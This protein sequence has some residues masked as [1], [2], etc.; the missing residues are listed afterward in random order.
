MKTVL[1]Y[2]VQKRLSMENENV[3][4]EALNFIINSSEAARSGLM[5]L[6]HGIDSDLPILRFQTQQTDEGLRPDFWGLDG[7]EPRVFIENKF[8]AGLTE[9]QPKEYLKLLT[10]YNQPTVLLLVVPEARLDSVWRELLQRIRLA[11]MSLTEKEPSSNIYRVAK[12]NIGPFLA[13]T[14]WNK[15][16]SAIEVELIDEPRTRNDLLQLR[17]LC[18]AADSD[19]FLPISAEELTNQRYPALILQLNSVVQKVVE[20][21]VNEKILLTE[22]LRPTHFWDSIGRYLSFYQAKHVYAWLGI[23]FRLWRQYGGTPLWLSFNN[24][25]WGRGLEIRPILEPWAEKQGI[26]T[27][28]KD[29]YFAISIDLAT[30]QEMDTVVRGVLERLND[31]AVQISVLPVKKM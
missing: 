18:D 8:W 3:A 31:I 1:S 13:L 2:I 29:N 14:S 22:G 6:L 10:R 21:G 23:R 7:K 12:T 24:S 28:D 30:G 15:L 27:I 19:A 16:L 11:D 20:Q 17:S 5:K 25:D 26:F 9:G 4:T